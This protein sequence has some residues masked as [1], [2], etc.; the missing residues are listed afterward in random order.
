MVLGDGGSLGPDARAR[1]PFRT[2]AGDALTRA[3]RAL[4]STRFAAH[5][6]SRL[7][8]RTRP[9]DCRCAPAIAG[10]VA[11]AAPLVFSPPSSLGRRETSAVSSRFGPTFRRDR[12]RVRPMDKSLPCGVSITGSGP[13]RPHGRDF[14]PKSLRVSRRVGAGGPGDEGFALARA[15]RIA[16]AE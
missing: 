6:R 15:E 14:G 7:W 12:E 3:L 1:R 9:F 4:Q 13:L 5:G 11:K 2:V 10:L 8:C 16:P